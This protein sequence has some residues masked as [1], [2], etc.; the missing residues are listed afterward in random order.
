MSCRCRNLFLNRF[1]FSPMQRLKN[2][3]IVDD[4]EDDYLIVSEYMHQIKQHSFEIVWASTFQQA[5]ELLRTHSFDLCFFDYLLGMRTGI[6][7]L[8]VAQE[9]KV[10]TP[11]ILL[12]GKINEEIDRSAIRLGVADYIEK[13]DLDAKKLERCIRYA[14]DRTAVLRALQDSEEKYRNIFSESLDAVCLLDANGHFTNANKAALVVL[15]TS[16]EQI[17]GKSLSDFFV[18]KTLADEF[19]KRL[20]QKENVPEL[21]ADLQATD[22]EVRNCVLICTHLTQRSHEE[23]TWFYQC[24]LR[25]VTRR[26]KMEQQIMAAE[27]L[28]ATGRFMRMLGHEIRNPLNNIDLS[29]TQLREESENEDLEYYF[30]IIARN[31]KRINQ[32]LTT[33]L[34]STSNPG[35]LHLREISVHQLWTHVL[36]A[37]IDRIRLKNI[38]LN[39]RFEADDAHYIRADL[40]KLGIALLNI[41][42]NGVEVMEAGSGILTL[43]VLQQGEELGFLI[44]DNGPGMTPEVRKQIF[45]PYFS[46]KTN[47][48]GLGLASTLSVVTLHEGRIEVESHPGK[49][50]TFIVWLPQISPP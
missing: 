13:S 24:I 18:D 11:I 41:I 47:G 5:Q 46:Q 19:S 17:Q 2:V 26:K 14:L 25:D 39:T 31:S 7:L 42:I 22:G 23:V 49:G 16:L 9:L 34:Q 35:E 12:T 29:V 32:L 43:S 38:E 10:R 30:D 15:G 28:A 44:S 3:L 27:K 8:H 33:L 36:E 45:E 37:A 20:Q 40:E 48:L 6:D 1:M 4:D 21:E 50:T